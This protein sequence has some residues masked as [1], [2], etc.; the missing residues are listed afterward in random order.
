MPVQLTWEQ[1]GLYRRFTDSVSSDFMVRVKEANLADERFDR[2]HYT[3]C[4]FRD[5][6]EFSSTP[7]DLDYLCAL[8]RATA[9]YRPQVCVAAV[10]TDPRVAAAV[11][12]MRD[13][14]VSPYPRGVFG[15]IEEAR[16]WVGSH[17]R[18]W[19]FAPPDGTP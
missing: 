4:D 5:V 16:A 18:A 3:I 1:H 6:A 17:L 12:A 9:L 11:Q 2:L 14:G 8:D 10:A 19:G 15:S 7:R 13:S